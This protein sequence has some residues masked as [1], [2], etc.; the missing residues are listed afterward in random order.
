M[1]SGGLFHIGSS[2]HDFCRVDLGA[3]ATMMASGNLFHNATTESHVPT[4]GDRGAAATRDIVGA[5][6]NLFHDTTTIHV[7]YTVDRGTCNLINL[8][9]E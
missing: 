6:G 3:A 8:L 7:P 9:R 2:H 5:S 4:P 1:A